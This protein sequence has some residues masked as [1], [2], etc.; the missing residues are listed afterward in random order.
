MKFH[1]IMASHNRRETTLR[2]ISSVA[3]AGKT[4]LLDVDVT[5]FDDGSTDETARS[6]LQRFPDV[7][8]ISGTGS[9]FWANSMYRAEERVLSQVGGSICVNDY[10]VW[11]ND[12]VVLDN[13]AFGRLLATTRNH[14][15]SILVAAMRDPEHL[16]TTYSGF[17]R[18]GRHPLRLS[19]VE[20]GHD[21]IP[22]DTFNGNLVLVPMPVALK[23]GSIDGEY[24]HA[25]ADIDYGYRAKIAEVPVLLA[26]GTYGTCARNTPLPRR[27][28]KE[29]WKTFTGV[30]GGGHPA[31]LM[32]ILRIGAPRTFPIY[33]V[34]TY[35]LWWMR[36]LR[37]QIRGATKN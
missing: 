29:E 7:T 17:S 1:V 36:A 18:R 26:P 27:N 16:Q 9:S 25:L 10:I 19:L 4:A 31:S 32:K 6:V 14:P 22:I 35:I 20:P 11:F 8:V 34:A 5:L 24:A 2:A 33:F 15:E 21:V 12:D 23:I 30:K 3:S 13:D 28:V 37:I